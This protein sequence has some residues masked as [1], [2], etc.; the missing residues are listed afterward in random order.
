MNGRKVGIYVDVEN[1][2]MNGGRGMQY[3]VLRAFACRGGGVNRLRSV[4]RLT[5]LRRCSKAFAR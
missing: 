3:D 2:T 4:G 1:I 5:M